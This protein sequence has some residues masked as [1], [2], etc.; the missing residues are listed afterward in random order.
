[1]TDI[2]TEHT[3]TKFNE[4]IEAIKAQVFKMAGLI[5]KQTQRSI[6]ALVNNDGNLADKVSLADYKINELERKIDQMCIETIAK[7]Q[8]TAI[9]LRFLI[10]VAKIIT[11]LER[12]G[13]ETERMGEYTLKLASKKYI[14][15]FYDDLSSLGEI[16]IKML[17]NALDSFARLD[18]EKAL[19]VLKKSDKLGKEF[20]RIMRVL[21]TYMMED[22][23]TIKAVLK[24]SWCARCLERIGAHSKNICEY[25][26]YLVK[27]KD[28]RHQ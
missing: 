9:D 24:V 22:P 27:G 7:R 12:I 10:A 5:E 20:D 1:M 14:S 18:D 16:V 2:N 21:V 8:P 23:R 15:D 28:I 19:A 4:E 11:D 17:S 26:V 3:S 25:T 13:D 6:R